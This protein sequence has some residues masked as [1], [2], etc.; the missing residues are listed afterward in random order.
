[1]VLFYFAFGGAVL[2]LL[3][4]MGDFLDER[5][6]FLTLRSRLLRLPAP[7]PRKAEDPLRH[8]FWHDLRLRYG[9]YA[10]GFKESKSAFT[11]FMV[12]PTIIFLAA[13]AVLVRVNDALP[14]DFGLELRNTA[15]LLI[16]IGL[17]LT[18]LA[19]FKGFYPKGS[20]S[21]MVFFAAMAL[22]TCLWIWYAALGGIATVNMADMA[23]VRVDYGQL[24]LLFI[25][26]AGLWAVYAVVEMVSYRPDWKRNGFYPVVD[27][28][29]KQRKDLEKAKRRMERQQRKQ[30]R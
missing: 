12:W 22:I 7:V 10:P 6:N 30:G 29:V 20:V 13:A 27:A 2:G 16:A 19:F 26:A 18:V 24:L 11:K 25:L 14:I 21:R 15:S 23:S 5:Y 1:M 8:R 28:E 17:P 9:R 3:I 4:Q